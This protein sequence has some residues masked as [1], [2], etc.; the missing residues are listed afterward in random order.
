MPPQSSARS[1]RAIP[2]RHLIPKKSPMSDITKETNPI[3]PIG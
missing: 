1:L 3:M 2:Q